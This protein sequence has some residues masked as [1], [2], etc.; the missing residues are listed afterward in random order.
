[1]KISRDTYEIVFI[2]YLEGRLND[3]DLKDL[4]SFLDQN[5]DLEAELRVVVETSKAK[6]LESKNSNNQFSFLKKESVLEN[7]TSNFE[8]LCICFYEGLL[9]DKEEQLLLELVESDEQLML[10][11]DQFGACYFKPDLSIVYPNK[12][13]LKRK[14]SIPF[15]RYTA[16]A[17]AV[18]LVLGFALMLQTQDNTTKEQFS[19]LPFEHSSYMDYP[20]VSFEANTPQF[21]SSNETNSN[22][23]SV[24][25]AQ[26]S[27][28]SKTIELNPKDIEIMNIEEYDYSNKY[29]FQKEVKYVSR[30]G[31]LAFNNPSDLENLWMQNIENSSVDNTQSTNITKHKFDDY[32]V[33]EHFNNLIEQADQFSPKINQ[34]MILGSQPH[35]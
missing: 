24:I 3:N 9:N 1:M 6:K 27:T 23:S 16:Y 25:K 8:E 2:D 20:K 13:S 14:K 19:N 12:A 17:A 29:T 18:I 33:N 15:Y 34:K 26:S 28:V 10:A 7:T 22:T 32:S 35:R 21:Y 30:K 31:K 5:P 11:F 4:V